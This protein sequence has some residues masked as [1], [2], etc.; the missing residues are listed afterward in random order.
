MADPSALENPI[1]SALTSGHES[2]ARV[3]G[4]ARRYPSAVSPLSAVGEPTPAALAD[5][6]ELV[7]PGEKVGLVAD[8]LPPVSDDWNLLLRRSIDQMVCP[9]IRDIARSSNQIEQLRPADVPEML[10]LTAL[11]EPGPFAPETI[12]MGGYFGIR[13]GGRLAAMAGERMC[14]TELQEISAV[15]T[16]PDFRGKGYGLALMSFLTARIFASGKTPFLH[17][18]TENK[19]AKLLYEKVGFHVRRP[20]EFIVI[21]RK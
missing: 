2:M 19:T 8:K 21:A 4:L 10:A 16:H 12:R 13:S 11:T 15:C 9:E 6:A 5:L 3:N 14:L 7:A 17:V 18:K 1:W 20:I